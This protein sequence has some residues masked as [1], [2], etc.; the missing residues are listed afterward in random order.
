MALRYIALLLCIMGVAAA[1]ALP[2]AADTLEDQLAIHSPQ[3]GAVV[4]GLVS[5]IGTADVAGMEGY[6][7]SFGLGV[8]PTQW[9]PIGEARSDTVRDGRLALWD[10]TRV[11]DGIYTL[12]LRAILR[13]DGAFAYRDV[14]VDGIQVSNAPR[15]ATPYPTLVPSATPTPTRPP[16]RTPT[17]IPTI[18]LEDGISPYLYLTMMDLHDPLCSGWRQRYSVW[19]SNVGA[20]SVTNLI[21]TQTLPVGLEPVLGDSTPGGELGPNQNAVIWRI[22]LLRPGEATKFELQVSVADWVEIGT[23]IT[24][25]VTLSS[26]Q[27]PYLAKSESSLLSDCVWLKQTVTARP[28]VMPTRSATETPTARPSPTTDEGTESGRPTLL[29]TA[30]RTL[31]IDI[32]DPSIAR[33]LDL[34]TIFISG[35]LGVLLVVT[36]LLLRRSIGPRIRS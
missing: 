7:V 11:P 14:Y 30:A 32:D 4:G 34:V 27:V 18:A 9:I 19:V 2:V 3:G 5:I 28:L 29:P 35:G 12:R 10:T 24:S 26:D 21:I 6:L 22:D 1:G 33:S 8:E 15:T 31:A 17:P 16:T 23:W 13:Q 36:I 25:Q 20:I